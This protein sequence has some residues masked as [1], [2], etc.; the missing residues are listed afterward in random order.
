MNQQ[1]KNKDSI[2]MYLNDAPFP[3]YYKKFFSEENFIKKK[4]FSFLIKKNLLN[5][6]NIRV[7]NKLYFQ[8]YLPDRSSNIRI[9]DIGC[10]TGEY[11]VNLALAYPNAE[12][13]GVDASLASLN[14]ADK[15]KKFLN[16]KNLKL[17]EHNIQ[18]ELKNFGKF[19]LILCAGVLH[20]LD[21]PKEVLKNISKLMIQNKT[22]LSLQI[23]C[24]YGRNLEK[25]TQ[26]GIRE[27]FPDDNKMEERLNFIKKTGLV[28]KLQ[29][30]GFPYGTK[31]TITFNIIRRIIYAIKTLFLSEYVQPTK[32]TDN[33]DAFVNPVCKFYNG[34]DIDKLLQYAAL[35]LVDFDFNPWF[36]KKFENIVDS[37]LKD[38]EKLVALKIKE[39]F[40]YPTD[41]I[42]ILK[43]LAPATN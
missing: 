35:E 20:H 13:I 37:Y 3:S 18:T 17:I 33:Y 16:I 21:H 36:S 32:D 5:K 39:K 8:K 4:F 40:I 15:L 42:L 14:L 7:K 19:D 9:L 12:V 2:S 41:Y 26:Q 31:K 28:R 25:Q 1:G 30:P 10:G 24:D 29:S 22:I 38:K 23:Y 43:S 27:L 34:E 6:N 11:T